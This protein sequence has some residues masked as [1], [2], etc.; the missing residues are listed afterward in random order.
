MGITIF[1]L[2]NEIMTEEDMK[3][4]LITNGITEEFF[5]HG[6]ALRS[7]LQ[8]IELS[9]AITNT[10]VVQGSKFTKPTH[11]FKKSL[12]SFILNRIK[13]LILIQKFL[14]KNVT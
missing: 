13:F 11:Y 3:R 2:F 1:D 5:G 12:K 6:L 10:T 4:F 8:M 9:P 7:L 14:L